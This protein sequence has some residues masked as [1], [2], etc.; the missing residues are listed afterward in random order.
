MNGISCMKIRFPP[1][2]TKK[3]NT[4]SLTTNLSERVC[5]SPRKAINSSWSLLLFVFSSLI[6]FLKLSWIAASSRKRQSKTLWNSVTF[7]HT[8]DS[9]ELIVKWLCKQRSGKIETTDYNVHDIWKKTL[10]NKPIK[11]MK[12]HLEKQIASSYLATTRSIKWI[13]LLDTTKVW[14]VL[15]E[16]KRKR[17]S[18]KHVHQ[19]TSR[20]N[21]W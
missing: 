9:L 1:N 2:I 20:V 8:Q 6:R 7:S 15:K 3:K 14:T 17:T 13:T 4:N 10:F 18:Q 19:T 11:N 12:H 16:I 21:L 5:L